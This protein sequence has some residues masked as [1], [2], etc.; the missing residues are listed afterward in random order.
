[1]NQLEDRTVVWVRKALCIYNSAGVFGLLNRGY[2]PVGILLPP[3][4]SRVVRAVV[5]HVNHCEE[6]VNITSLSPKV[7]HLIFHGFPMASVHS[8]TIKCDETLLVCL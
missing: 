7:R 1:M 3:V 5:Q 8:N 2:G 4:N 6:K